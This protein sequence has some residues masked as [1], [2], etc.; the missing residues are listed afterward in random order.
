MRCMNSYTL[1]KNVFSLFLNV[2]VSV[3]SGARSA[4]D[5]SIHEVL[6]RRNCGHRSLFWC[7]E[8][9][10]G[11]SDRA[12]TPG[13]NC[14]RRLTV[15]GAMHV[16]QTLVDRNCCLERDPPSNGSQWSRIQLL[17][18]VNRKSYALYRMLTFP[19]SLTGPYRSRNFFKLSQQ[20][21]RTDADKP[22]RRV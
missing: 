5:C 1:N 3:M 17:Y 21:A 8:Q 20:E 7:V 14:W 2:I 4:A 22:A 10:V 13:S 19:I 16:V 12:E 15:C 6:G 9:P 11:W 18:N